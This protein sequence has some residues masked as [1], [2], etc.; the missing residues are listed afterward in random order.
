MNNR[1]WEREQEIKEMVPVVGVIALLFI[2]IA[3]LTLTR[4]ISWAHVGLSLIPMA[5]YLI[6]FRLGKFWLLLLPKQREIN[7]SLDWKAYLGL[8]VVMLP[9]TL[10][11]QMS[12]GA[13]SGFKL[14][15]LPIILVYSLHYGLLGGNIACGLASIVILCFYWQARSKDCQNLQLEADLITIG[16]FFLVN[17]LVAKSYQELVY[18]FTLIQ[19]SEKLAALGEMTAATVHEIRNPLTTLRGFLQMMQTAQKEEG[20]A[21]DRDLQHDEY[22]QLM[23]AEIDRINTIIADVL[24]FANPKPPNLKA[25][26][27]NIVLRKMGLLLEGLAQLRGVQVRILTVKEPQIVFL[28]LDQIK[29]VV[30]NLATNAFDAM[31]FGGVLELALLPKSDMVQ[32]EFIDTGTGM[33]KEYLHKIFEPFFTSREKKGGSGLGLA[34][35]HRI[36]E[37]H[38]G[39]ITVKSKL[40]KGTTF[41]ISFPRANII[42]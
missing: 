30:L 1:L 6:V 15:F 35:S 33:P 25:M 31:P 40:G 41:T 18:S 24:L 34:I 27:L 38:H 29:Q 37:N 5:L 13:A 17:W 19:R 7:T 16:I 2:C 22:F 9:L 21:S 4:E 11:L 28:D 10:L 26:D 12:G 14:L 8:A 32:L 20:A 23:L 3:L 42:Q 36:I 39:T